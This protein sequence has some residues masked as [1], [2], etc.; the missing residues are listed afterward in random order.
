[1]FGYY[2]DGSYNKNIIMYCGHNHNI[3]YNQFID[4]YFNINPDLTIIN[5]HNVKL[6]KADQCII[7]KDNFDYFMY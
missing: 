3:F 6:K 7:F 5:H 2:S 1:M 4:D